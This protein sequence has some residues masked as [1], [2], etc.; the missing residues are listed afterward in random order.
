M[1]FWLKMIGTWDGPW[2]EGNPYDRKHI[3]FRGRKPSGIHPGDQMILYAVR[4]KRIFAIVDVTSEYGNNDEDGWNFR[5]D[6]RWPPEVNLAQSAGVDA[7]EVSA[8]LKDR[9]R[10]KS[11][12][13]LSPEEFDLAA[14]KLREASNRE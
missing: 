13:R 2:P 4:R 3:G 6:I 8:D 9:V 7:S 1:T 5:V 10:R 11:H 14:T 12:I